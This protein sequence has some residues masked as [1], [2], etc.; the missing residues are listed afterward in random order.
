MILWLMIYY[1]EQLNQFELPE[2]PNGRIIL[3]EE[4]YIRFSGVI[5]LCAF[6]GNKNL[7]YGTILYG[8]EIEPNVL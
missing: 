4:V 6:S 2:L 7:E 1:L 3:S 5:N 8:K